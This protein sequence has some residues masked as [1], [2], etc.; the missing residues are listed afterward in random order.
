[1]VLIEV[2]DDPH[3]NEPGHK[4]S[5]HFP[6]F[7]EVIEHPYQSEQEGDGKRLFRAHP[8]ILPVALRADKIP[9]DVPDEHMVDLVLQEEIHI[10]RI[11]RAGR[12]MH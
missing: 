1:M 4:D 3:D 2:E 5:G 6:V 10:A 9:E 12:F 7:P 8:C 11:I